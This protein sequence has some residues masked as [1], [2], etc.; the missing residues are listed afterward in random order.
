MAASEP[1]N[2]RVRYAFGAACFLG[3]FALEVVRLNHLERAGP[4]WLIA[5]FLAFAIPMALSGLL[6]L[7]GVLAPVTV[8]RWE[9]AL[10]ESSDPNVF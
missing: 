3:L 1:I 4:W 5:L 10:E 8:T 6:F 7:A 2:P 9:E